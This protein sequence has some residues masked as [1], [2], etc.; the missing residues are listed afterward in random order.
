MLS[1]VLVLKKLFL[2]SNFLHVVFVTYIGFVFLCVFLDIL[3][4]L[5]TELNFLVCKMTCSIKSKSKIIS[6]LF[7]CLFSLFTMHNYSY[8]QKE[9]FCSVTIGTY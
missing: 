1:D 6:F 9:L 5:L 8:Q 7:I 2:T 4:Y 3:F